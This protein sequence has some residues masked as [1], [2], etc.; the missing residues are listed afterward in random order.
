VNKEGP[1]YDPVYLDAL[2]RENR[3]Y[4]RFSK[5]LIIRRIRES[6]MLPGLGKSE[7]VDLGTFFQVAPSGTL[8]KEDTAF[9]L[10]NY[11]STDRPYLV[12]LAEKLSDGVRAGVAWGVSREKQIRDIIKA[13]SVPEYPLVEKVNLPFGCISQSDKSHG[14]AICIGK[15]PRIRTGGSDS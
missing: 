11:Q 6:G 3:H 4:D 1:E 7:D 5:R 8:G 12:A 2:L 9:V 10:E 14:C 15:K 13:L